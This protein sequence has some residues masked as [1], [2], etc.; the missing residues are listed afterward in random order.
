MAFESSISRTAA[1]V[2]ITVLAHLALTAWV[3]RDARAR[4]LD[5]SPWDLLTLA[6]GVVGALV[7]RRRR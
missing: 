2:A 5:P 3:R 6:T 1:F 7:Y 4:G